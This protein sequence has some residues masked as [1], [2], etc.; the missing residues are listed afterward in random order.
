MQSSNLPTIPSVCSGSDVIY[1][2]V[3][4]ETELRR[5]LS[6]QCLGQYPLQLPQQQQQQQLSRIELSKPQT[7][8]WIRPNLYGK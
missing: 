8:Q 5:T 6:V 1:V 2:T 3:Q 7:P 4:L